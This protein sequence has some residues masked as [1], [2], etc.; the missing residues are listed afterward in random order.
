MKEDDGE[1]SSGWRVQE[2]GVIAIGMEAACDAG[3]WWLLDAQAL[4]G[5][6]ALSSLRSRASTGAGH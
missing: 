1:F 4:A 6:R 2:D 3:V 5:G